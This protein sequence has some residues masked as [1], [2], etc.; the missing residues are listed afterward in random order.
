[1]LQRARRHVATTARVRCGTDPPGTLHNGRETM[2]ARVLAGLLTVAT[3]LLSIQAQAAPTSTV[4]FQ[5]GPVITV[6][7]NG[8]SVSG[9][10]LTAS[11]ASPIG[12]ATQ[13]ILQS[14][15]TGALTALNPPQVSATEFNLTGPGA[16]RHRRQH[17]RCACRVE[18]PILGGLC[19]SHQRI[20]RLHGSRPERFAGFHRPLAARGT[21]DRSADH[22]RSHW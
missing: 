8:G 20:H 17:R 16:R 9:A 12:S 5:D 21:A 13:S 15:G 3:G 18:R 14:G 1:M 7:V 11:D 19:R 6:P 2:R 4:E 10:G 22:Q